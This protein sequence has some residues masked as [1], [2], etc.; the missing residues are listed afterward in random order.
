MS[1]VPQWLQSFTFTVTNVNDT[2]SVPLVQWLDVTSAGMVAVGF[3]IRASD[4]VSSESIDVKL[5]TA[6]YASDITGLARTCET[7]T[8]TGPLS[9]PTGFPLTAHSGSGGT[10][11]EGVIGAIF[12]KT[13]GSTAATITL[14]AYVLMKR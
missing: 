12:E 11:P 14:D 8:L 2:V 6:P 1:R 7:K 3:E 13:A 10:P 5:V 9:V 4:L